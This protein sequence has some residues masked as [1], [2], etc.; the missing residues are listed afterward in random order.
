MK[1]NTLALFCI[2]IAATTFGQSKRTWTPK[3]IE[4]LHSFGSDTSDIR[5]IQ[6]SVNEASM[7]HFED[8]YKEFFN[9]QFKSDFYRFELKSSEIPL[10]FFHRPLDIYEIIDLYINHN[11]L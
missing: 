6:L 11:K 7:I 4:V 5:G 3:H 9:G 2:V 10:A 1:L 8:V